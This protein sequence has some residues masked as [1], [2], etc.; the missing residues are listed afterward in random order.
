V[1]IRHLNALRKGEQTKAAI[2]DAA[3]VLASRDGLEGLTIGL[4]ADRMGMSKSGVFAHFGSREDLQIEVVREYHRRFEQEVFFTAIQEPRGLPRLVRLFENWVIRV[5]QEIDSGC[6][7]I[8]GAVEFDE[9]PGIVRDELFEMIRTWQ[10]ALL[11]AATQ[12]VEMGHLAAD[13]D[14]KQLVFEMHGLI[15]ALHHDARFMQQPGSVQRARKGFAR[16]V[17]AMRATTSSS[18]HKV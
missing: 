2:L 4:L 17:D 18:T 15:L 1:A 10:G 8:S 6:I 14:P 9:R 3:L 5:T 12:A 16:L 11:K 13:T 7:Y